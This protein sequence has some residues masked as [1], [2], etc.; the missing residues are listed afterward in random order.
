[1]YSIE[2]V[3]DDFTGA[4]DT[5]HGFASRGYGTAVVVD[6]EA[7]MR[8][9]EETAVVLGVNTD[10]RYSDSA[11]AYDTVVD[12]IK[13]TSAKTVYKK[14][15]STLRGNFATEVDAALT[16]VGAN[17]ALVVPAFPAA[18]RT[19]KDGVHY[20]NGTPVTDT[21]YGDDE[22]GPAY[23]SIPEL[24]SPV[25]RTIEV[26]SLST[27]ES[28]VAEVAVTLADVIESAKRP[29]IIVCD[30]LEAAHVATAAEAATRFDPLYVGS[31]ELAKHIMITAEQRTPDSFQQSV[32][33]APMGIVGSVSKTTL[34]QLEYV[35]DDLIIRIDGLDLVK[36]DIPTESIKQAHARL[37]EDQPVILTAATSDED[38]EQTLTAGHE[39]GL[40]N[41][42]I[43]GRVRDGLATTATD[44]IRNKS[45]TGLFIT[46]G[47]IAVAVAQKLDAT[48]VTLFGEEVEAGIP[49]GAFADGDTD[50]M[51]LITKAG[52]FG[53]KEA[54]SRCLKVLTP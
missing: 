38:V 18:G 12:S 51:P 34:T 22:K 33:G 6:P 11:V 43:R 49:I 35:P 5:S 2:V 39:R 16:S 3:A 47:D 50:G 31:A 27:I 46:G 42:T 41:S 4:M 1:M 26:V 28:G 24:F 45:P 7:E 9:I 14:V 10:T 37:C 19:T 13:K 8:A 20:V 30:A 17:F 29:P 23:S 44:V 25:G 54:I 15:D 32:T 53:S 40:S 48:V 21:E 36:G 52:G